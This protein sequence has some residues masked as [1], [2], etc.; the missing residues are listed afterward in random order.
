MQD[1]SSAAPAGRTARTAITLA[2]MAMVA[3]AVP[4]AG[5]ATDT[6]RARL[7][8]ASTYQGE[9]DRVAQELAVRRRM[10]TDWQRMLQE[11][12]AKMRVDEPDTMRTQTQ[13]QYRLVLSRFRDLSAESSVLRRQLEELCSGGPR[14]EGW[15]GLS[16]YSAR[17]VLTKQGDGPVAMQYLERPVVESVDP[18]SPADRA[19]VRANDVIVAMNGQSLQSGNVVPTD[20]LRPG[21]RVPI[22]VL[23]DGET[24]TIIVL[25][26]P[27]PDAL[28]TTPCP[29]V[30]ATIATAL[31]PMP[32]EVVFLERP[33]AAG[34]T[35]RAMIVRQQPRIPAEVADSAT[36]FTRST[37]PPAPV[38]AFAGTMYATGGGSPV[39][40][41]SLYPVNKDLGQ[42]FGTE[43]GLLVLSVLPGTT[44]QRAG[45][46]AGDVLLSANDTELKSALTLQRLISRASAREVLVAFLRNKQLDSVTLRWP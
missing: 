46:R 30:D 13:A 44:A 43:K 27:R 45:L 15:M 32:N 24:R 2:S 40:G 19:G 6:L 1:R 5:Q 10:L 29:Y 14:P 42:T 8:N 4:A 36:T 21:A 23:R 11:L 22:R 37:P 16:L 39:A 34:P 3:F 9:I 18:G 31:A 26:A 33:V 12:Q 28:E 41:L 38:P 17:V 20:M 7:R 35:G 25:V